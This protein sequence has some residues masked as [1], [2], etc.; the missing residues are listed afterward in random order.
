MKAGCA[1]AAAAV[2]WLWAQPGFGQA[3]AGGD[4]LLAVEPLPDGVSD[5]IAGQ[6]ADLHWTIERAAAEARGVPAA[7]RLAAEHHARAVWWVSE[8]AGGFVLRLFDVRKRRVLERRFAREGRGTLARSA[9]LE[10]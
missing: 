7:T 3:Q 5:R 2:C 4:R 6:T 10:A 9:A 1:L 8:G